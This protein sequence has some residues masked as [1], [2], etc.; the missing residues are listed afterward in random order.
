[1]PRCGK[2]SLV[3]N[4]IMDIKFVTKLLMFI[5]T[6]CYHA[7]VYLTLSK[8]PSLEFINE[9]PK[10]CCFKSIIV[11]IASTALHL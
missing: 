8:R 3:F 4:S 11:Q 2:T 9:A 10:I 6:K 1:M 7:D 5:P